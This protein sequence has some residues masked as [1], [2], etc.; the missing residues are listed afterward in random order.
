MYSPNLVQGKLCKLSFYGVFGCS[1]AA[2]CKAALHNV[3][4]LTSLRVTTGLQLKRLVY[5]RWIP[6]VV[7]RRHELG[8]ARLDLYARHFG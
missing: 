3:I 4:L 1:Y 5:R 8:R 6:E 2:S 7:G